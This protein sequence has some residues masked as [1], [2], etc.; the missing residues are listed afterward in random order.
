MK[1]DLTQI[2][3]LAF[4]AGDILLSGYNPRPG[5]GNT[6]QITHKG[7]IDLVTEIDHRSEIFI[8]D[9]IRRKFPDDEIIAE[10]SGKSGRSDCC[11]WYIDPLDGTINYAHGVPLFAVSIAYQSEG[12]LQLGVVYDPI[13]KE[14]FSAERGKGARLNGEPIQ[15]SHT[16]KII[17]SLLVT[18]F[19]YDIRENPE[20]NLN[21]YSK[22]SMIS[23]GVR[24]LGSAALDLCYVAAGRFDGFWE[25]H[26][27]PWD[28]AAGGL[29]AMEAGAVVTDVS[30]DTNF[31]TMD[32]SILAANTHLHSQLLSQLTQAIS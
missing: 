17:E 5:F 23:Q 11:I 21:H 22:M 25:L 18:G 10:E 28:I 31:I 4:Q 20:N 14:C 7:E 2:E 27:S 13:H 32:A 16:H 1:P 15:V 29:I 3:Q 8:I 19:P 26:T 30:G 24:R 9:E 12:F 6:L